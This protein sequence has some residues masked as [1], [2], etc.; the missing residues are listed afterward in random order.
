[1]DDE[2]RRYIKYILSFLFFLHPK[3]LGLFVELPR[4]CE[5][6]DSVRPNS[7]PNTM[8]SVWPEHPNERQMYGYFWPNKVEMHKTAHKCDI[9]DQLSV[10]NLSTGQVCKIIKIDPAL[11]VFFPCNHKRSFLIDV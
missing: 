11:L 10:A 2:E 1:M 3:F 8:C 4:N 5:E 7:R 6:D 9:S